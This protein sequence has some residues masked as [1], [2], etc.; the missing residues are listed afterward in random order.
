MSGVVDRRRWLIGG[1]GALGALLASRPAVSG[2]PRV[3]FDALGEIRPVY[4]PELV[5]EILASGTRAIAVTVTDP[6]V[7]ADAAFAQTLADLDIYDAYLASLPRHYLRARR[8]ADADLAARRGRLAVFYN[9]QNSTP[10]EGDAARLPA[11]KARGVTS[12]QLTY[13]DTNRSG[14][15]CYAPTDEGVTAHGRD[16]IERLER[17]RMLIDLSHA[18][19]R[20]MA[21]AISAARRPMIISHTT[22]RALRD[23]PRATTD[24]ALRALADGGGVVGITQIRRFLT[25]RKRDNLPAYFDHIQHAVK[26]AGIEH[27]GIGSDR[28]HRVIPD[29]EAELQ[30]LMKEEGPQLSRD[31]WP[32]YL[33]GLNGPHRMT[34][35]RDGLRQRG[36]S[37]AQIDKLL[38]ANVRRLYA[39]VVG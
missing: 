17:A 20:T 9:L 6:K 22:C 19:V 29:T 2:Q 16:L 32:M 23:H 8:S 33:E 38:G 30:I 39:E 15:G 14:S 4:T 5:D 25:D 21:D 12:I 26:V 10:V 13:N 34:V 27:V 7:A 18:G 37:Q 1:A 11:L 24:E 3:V 31:D 36:F 28:D 35:V